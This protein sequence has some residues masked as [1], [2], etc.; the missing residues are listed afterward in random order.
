M[1]VERGI[2]GPSDVVVV[3]IKSIFFFWG[4]S[5]R[6]GMGGKTSLVGLSNCVKD[7]R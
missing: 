3:R 5:L 6:L 1:G 7:V 2:I 4:M